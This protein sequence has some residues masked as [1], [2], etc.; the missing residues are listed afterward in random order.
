MCG[1]ETALESNNRGKKDNYFAATSKIP[2][3]SKF[4]MCNIKIKA[5]SQ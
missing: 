2:R 1:I 3:I 5:L 4:Q